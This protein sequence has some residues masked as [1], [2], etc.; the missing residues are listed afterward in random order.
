[1]L[2]VLA[3]TRCSCSC[4][5]QRNRVNALHDPCWAAASVQH[6]GYQLLPPFLCLPTATATCNNRQQM[7][8]S[9]LALLLKG[10]PAFARSCAHS[11]QMG[12]P[13][14][15]RMNRRERPKLRAH[16]RCAGITTAGAHCAKHHLELGF[17]AL[18]EVRQ[19]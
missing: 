2:I 16:S 15:R 3:L 6:H 10:E 11:G 17:G 7:S 14:L 8:H 4:S 9:C 13:R 19:A 12:L 1:V 5:R 18:V